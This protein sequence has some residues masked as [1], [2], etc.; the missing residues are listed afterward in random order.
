MGMKLRGR[1]AI[2]L[3]V[4]IAA[5]A[6]LSV[7]TVATGSSGHRGLSGSI[8]FMGVWSG[9]DQK[10][11]EAVF[12]AF[13][14]ANP[15]VKV[16]YTSAGD[17]L[18]TVLGTAVQGGNPPDLAALPQP[19]LLRDF[20]SRGKLQPINFARGVISKNYAPVWLSLGSVGKNLYGLF[21]KGANKSTVWY[22][23]PA[24]K[25]AGVKPPKTWPQLLAAAKTLRAS[26]TV[27]YSVGGADGWTLTDL[28]ENIYIRQAGTEEVRPAHPAQDQV[29]RSV[30]QGNPEDHGRHPG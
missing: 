20:Q 29:D 25:A 16:K 24:F 9:A 30:G 26:G 12:A 22:N 1:K 11:I 6:S 10:S 8:S 19:G 23:V 18:P 28:M 14:K 15:G 4:A 17:Q 27:P 3:V 21:F 5:V 7:T 13:M 2:A